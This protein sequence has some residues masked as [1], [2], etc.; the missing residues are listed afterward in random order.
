MMDHRANMLIT[1]LENFSPKK[2]ITSYICST[3]RLNPNI[4]PP[5]IENLEKKVITLC[6]TNF[7]Q[8]LGNYSPNLSLINGIFDLLNEINNFDEANTEMYMTASTASSLDLS[9]SSQN[10]FSR[11]N[12]HEATFLL[13]RGEVEIS[14]NFKAAFIRFLQIFNF[15]KQ[16]V[17]N[18]LSEIVIDFLKSNRTADRFSIPTFKFGSFEESILARDCDD[19]LHKRWFVA[20]NSYLE[21]IQ[22]IEN[23]GQRRFGCILDDSCFFDCEENA[24]LRVSGLGEGSMYLFEYKN[25]GFP[26]KKEER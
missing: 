20:K 12:A 23:S 6:N 1:Y 15:K 9:F 2:I 26:F 19:F 14:G 4:D 22:S 13:M 10:D 25:P 11:S 21:S 7:F 5:K 17:C 18:I 8:T 24:D 16:S 3:L